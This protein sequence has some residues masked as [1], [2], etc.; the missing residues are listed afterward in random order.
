MRLLADTL[1]LVFL[2]L[3]AFHGFAQ[4]QPCRELDIYKVAFEDLAANYKDT[5]VIEIKNQRG[6]FLIDDIGKGMD[7]TETQL[8]Q[9]DSTLS[10]SWGRERCAG[11]EALLKDI[12]A[13]SPRALKDTYYK[14]ICSQPIFLNE[15]KAVLLFSFYLKQKSGDGGKP[16][17]ADVLDTY[18]LDEIRWKRTNRQALSFY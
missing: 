13:R 6:A 2:L 5:L 3:P 11:I 7:A 9:I 12:H 4:Y 10:Q 15:K 18:V 17:G 1:F 8:K 16:I 14:I